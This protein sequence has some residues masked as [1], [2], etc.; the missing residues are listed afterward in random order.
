VEKTLY[1]IVAKFRPSTGTLD[2]SHT[3]IGVGVQDQSAQGVDG[4]RITLHFENL[5]QF[6]SDWRLRALHKAPQF[7]LKFR[8]IPIPACVH[9]RQSQID[10]WCAQERQEKRHVRLSLPKGRTEQADFFGRV[11]VVSAAQGSGVAARRRRS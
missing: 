2:R 5:C 8:F 6:R 11:T 7:L 3:N 4:P 9:R 10:L 1:V